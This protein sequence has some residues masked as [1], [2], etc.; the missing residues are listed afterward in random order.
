[1]CP[2][3]GRVVL[4]LPQW[5]H[6]MLSILSLL[7]AGLM[8]IL[9]KLLPMKGSDTLDTLATVGKEDID[10]MIKNVHETH[11][12][13]GAEAEGNVTFPFLAIK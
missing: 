11:Q 2:F 1:M 8:L 10:A 13:P 6:K 4:L 3:P 12:T 9:Q 5:Q 7:G